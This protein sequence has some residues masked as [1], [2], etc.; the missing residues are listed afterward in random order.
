MHRFDFNDEM[1]DGGSFL[2][3]YPDWQTSPILPVWSRFARD[4]FGE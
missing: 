3:D 1:G 4:V 2:S